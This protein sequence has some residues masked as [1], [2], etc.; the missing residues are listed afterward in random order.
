MDDELYV[1]VVSKYNKLLHFDVLKLCEILCVDK[2]GF[3]RSGH[4]YIKQCN[5]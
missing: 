1:T 3:L 4:I 2:T 5:A